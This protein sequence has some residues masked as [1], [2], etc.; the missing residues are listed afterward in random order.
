[1]SR[2]SNL[3]PV[4]KT[5]ERI[6]TERKPSKVRKVK[7]FFE[8]EDI[9][10]YQLETMIMGLVKVY[11][12]KEDS[13]TVIDL[14]GFQEEYYDRQSKKK[15][16]DLIR[17]QIEDFL[18]GECERGDYDSFWE[19]FNIDK[20]EWVE[21]DKGI[22]HT[23]L[24]ER[25]EKPEKNSSLIVKQKE[26]NNK[27]ESKHHMEKQIYKQMSEFFSNESAR[28]RFKLG[29]SQL[30]GFVGGIEKGNVI[31]IM[32]QSVDGRDAMLNTLVR[33]MAIDQQ[34]PSL[35]LNLGTNE[36]IFYYRLESNINRVCFEEVREDGTLPIHKSLEDAELY[37][38]FPAERKIEYIEKTIRDY[39]AKGIELVFI[40][41]F[42]MIDCNE[43]AASHYKDEVMFEERTARGLYALAK[44]LSLNI[45]I[46]STVNNRLE[47]SDGLSEELPR[48]QDLIHAGRLD[49]YSDLVL[50][51]YIPYAHQNHYHEDVRD[52]IIVS[53][54]KNNINMKMGK[55]KMH[56]DLYH[57]NIWDNKEY[58]KQLFEEMKAENSVI[59][60]MAIGMDLELADNDE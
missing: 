55:F 20:L 47:Y 3:K 45:I 6:L 46:G 24:Q 30:D 16:E 41:S 28:K 8:Y 4:L 12:E 21:I 35:F 49:E 50:G 23:D 40:D 29:L 2:I 19:D 37:V 1:M 14:M 57:C 7:V 38:E 5:L 52:A 34:I 26:N 22:E 27:Q 43:E 25:I 60:E 42:Q 53:V 31:V 54:L 56:Y 13:S 17:Y 44:D 48:I 10:Y 18:P 33:N 32:G 58:N 39:A 11:I 15:A 59:N 36:R 9:G 51:T